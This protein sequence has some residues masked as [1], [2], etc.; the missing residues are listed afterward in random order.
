MSLSYPTEMRA[1]A[2]KGYEG[3]VHFPKVTGIKMGMESSKG[4]KTLATA[5]YS[6]RDKLR[7]T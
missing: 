1:V 5:N 2:I 7:K 6:C 3:M 4:Q